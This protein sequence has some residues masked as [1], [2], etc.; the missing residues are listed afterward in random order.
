MEESQL[1]L[2]VAGTCDAVLMV[3]AGANELS[4]QVIQEAILFGHDVIKEIIV[5]QNTIVAAVGLPKREIKMY[6]PP[7][8][9]DEV[10]RAH[11]TDAMRDAVTNSDKLEREA[12]ISDVKKQAAEHFAEIY[13]DNKKDVSYVVYKVLKE[14]V[15]R[16]ITVDKIRP[17]GDVSSMKFGQSPVKSACCLVCMV[18]ACLPGARLR[19]LT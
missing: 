14:T 19:C 3:E 2:I 18:P 9:L 6:A 11:V 1:D 5:F 12:K 7:A 13:P 16:M 8:D 15:R 4:E 17:D 10:V